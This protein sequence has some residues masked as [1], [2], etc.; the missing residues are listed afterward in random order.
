QVILMYVEDLSNGLDFIHIA[1]EIT[2]EQE[3]TKP[4]LALKSGRTAEGAR[5][6]ASHTGS[7]AGTDEVYDALMAQAGV[8][9]V[10][11]VQELF[12]YAMAFADQPMPRSDRI[13][14]VTNAG[15]PGIM[16][17]DACVRQG[18]ELADLSDETCKILTAALPAAAS[19]KN[20][21]DVLGDAQH[22]RYQATLEAVL[23]DDNVDGLVVILTPQNMTDIEEIARGIT[24]LD[25][26]CGK[27]I[28]TSFMGGA[29]VAAGVQILRQHGVPHYPFPEGASRVLR[30]MRKYRRWLDRERTY[31][32]IFDVDR[33]KVQKIFTKAR[34]EGRTQ[35]P[36]MEALQVLEAYGF[37]VL[38]SGLAA[39]SGDLPTICDQVGFPLVMKIASPDILHKTDIGGVEVGVPDLESAEKV[40]ARMTATVRQHYPDANLWGIEIQQMA[41]PGREVILGATRDPKF[42]PILMFGM[43]GI[44]TEA[45]KD[46]TF[47]LAPLR[48]LAARH[49]LE[50][51][52]GRK[53]LEGIRGE[54]PADFDA[55]QECLERL[56][57]LVIEFP[58]IEELDIN[59]LIAYGEG[60]AVADARIILG[61]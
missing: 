51:I 47:R 11:T 30:A 56:S 57:Q 27:P 50:E 37:P 52:R 17:T 60:A 13:A 39:T 49:M 61:D 59:P 20:P 15:G 54:V 25:P 1:R 40:F 33:G 31:E 9:R 38:K 10:D 41:L 34:E 42:G 36:E 4:I 5:A 12:D 21:V 53:I 26:D 24:R 43:G 18:L 3:I 55:I 58:V 16:A 19:V 32:R 48:Q 22:D 35:L 6:A 28:L 29:D 44:Y 7:M 8:L 23:K 46:V 45:L 2:S 14:I